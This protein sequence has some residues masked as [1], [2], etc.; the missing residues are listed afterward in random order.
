[1][2]GDAPDDA[3]RYDGLLLGVHHLS[4]GFVNAVRK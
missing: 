4:D 3:D 2:A 1:M